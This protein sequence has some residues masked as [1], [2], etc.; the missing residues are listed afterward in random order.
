ML[1]IVKNE[2][3]DKKLCVEKKMEKQRNNCHSYNTRENSKNKKNSS[4]KEEIVTKK[5]WNNCVGSVLDTQ[6]DNGDHPLW[7]KASIEDKM[8]LMMEASEYEE[9]RD[10]K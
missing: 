1:S 8:N 6:S 10:V 9:V 2:E 7:R 4:M 3:A 5:A